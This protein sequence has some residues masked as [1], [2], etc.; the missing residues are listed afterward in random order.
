MRN[1]IKYIL[2]LIIT[3][4]SIAY[5]TDEVQNYMDFVKVEKEKICVVGLFV[6]TTNENGQFFKDATP[7]WSNLEQLDKIAN[8][9]NKNLYAVYTNY[10]SDFT[11]PY[12]YVL[13]YEVTNLDV[14]PEGMLGIEIPSSSYAAFTAKGEFP[15]S[16][17]EI[18][19]GIWSSNMKR[20]YKSDFEIYA[21]D[22]NPNENSEVKIFISIE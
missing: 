15:K 10:E 17:I 6:R 2:T 4:S 7:M 9:V 18:W 12:T 21:E 14:I 13:G 22:F 8:P 20:A 3:V 11:K 16:V 5:A 1:F 19:N